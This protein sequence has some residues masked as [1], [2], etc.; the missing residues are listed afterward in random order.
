MSTWIIDGAKNAK[1][2]TINEVVIT[3][4][5]IFWHWIWSFPVANEM[6]A[7]EVE[8]NER[9]LGVRVCTWDP[10]QGLY[11]LYALG[12]T[13]EIQHNLDHKSSYVD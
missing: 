4:T 13:Y 12:P 9:G 11:P 7:M 2:T 8:L 5:Q 10:E 6:K 1:G 3:D